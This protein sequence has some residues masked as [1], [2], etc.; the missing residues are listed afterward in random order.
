[1]GWIKIDV[2]E[3]IKIMDCE[4]DYDIEDFMEYHKDTIYYKSEKNLS[5]FINIY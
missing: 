3:L 4:G 2:Q 5:D 1:M